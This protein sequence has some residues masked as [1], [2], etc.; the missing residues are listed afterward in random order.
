MKNKAVLDSMK[1]RDIHKIC[2]ACVIHMIFYNGSLI[3]H[4][5]ISQIIVQA[6][7]RNRNALKRPEISSKVAIDGTEYLIK[8]DFFS[9]ADIKMS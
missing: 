8:I 6:R 9:K 2:R 4:K 7:K 3:N 5:A 1:V